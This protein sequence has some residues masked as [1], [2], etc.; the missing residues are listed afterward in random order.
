MPDWT[1]LEELLLEELL[2][3]LLL[4]LLELLLEIDRANVAFSSV[5]SSSSSFVVGIFVVNSLLFTVERTDS[6]FSYPC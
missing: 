3:L 5:I 1:L 4:E 6:M 2:E